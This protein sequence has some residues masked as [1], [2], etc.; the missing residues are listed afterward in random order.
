MTNHTAPFLLTGGEASVRN[1][2]HCR[3]PPVYFSLHPVQPSLDYTAWEYIYYIILHSCTVWKSK[4]KVA[5]PPPPYP[6]WLP[7]QKADLKT[8]S[9]TSFPAS[10]CLVFSPVLHNVLRTSHA[11]LNSTPTHNFSH[12]TFCWLV[13]TGPSATAFPPP[14]SPLRAGRAEAQGKSGWGVTGLP[15]QHR[16]G[17]PHHC[18]L[19]F[20]KRAAKKSS[21]GAQHLTVTVTHG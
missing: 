20:P 5:F 4:V 13:R 2:K 15:T 17:R 19:S 14:I 12:Q 16:K 7:K 11:E 1:T 18:F 3:S 21:P 8:C 9:C 10:D 6:R